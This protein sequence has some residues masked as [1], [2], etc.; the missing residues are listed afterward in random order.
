M[1]IENIFSSFVAYDYIDYDYQSVYN[2]FYNKIDN[3]KEKRLH[4][5]SGDGID[6]L[7]LSI[8]QKAN[9]IAKEHIKLRDNFTLVPDKAWLNTGYNEFNSIPHLHRESLLTCVLYITV[10]EM[11]SDLHLLNPN[12][13]LSAFVD[14]KNIKESNLYN[15]DK[16]IIPPKEGKLIIFPS[17]I[18]HRIASFSYNND[19]NRMSLAV[20]MIAVENNEI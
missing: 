7:V 14:S 10:G 13:T 6:N 18:M 17:W 2:R 8:T 19:D 11:S 9:T 12:N 15:S 20:N 1:E 16:W 5:Y 3:T 4:I